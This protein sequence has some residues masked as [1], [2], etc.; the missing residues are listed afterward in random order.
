MTRLRAAVGGLVAAAVAAAAAT[1][2]AAARAATDLGTP[3]PYRV[4]HLTYRLPSLRVPDFAV[5]LEVVGEVEAPVGAPG[6]RPLVLVLHGMHRTCLK[7]SDVSA[8][9]PGRGWPCPPGWV[10]V[11]NHIGYRWLLR[12]LASQGDVAVSVSANSVNAQNNDVPAS[13]AVERALLVRHHLRLWA[14]WATTGG[15]PWGG[16]MRGA[17]DPQRVVLV[18]HSRGGEGVAQASASS[19]P[20]DA[21]RVRGLVLIAPTHFGRQVTPGVDE[22][23]VLPYCD[24]DVNDLEGQGYID[25]RRDLVAGD[26]TVRS[27]LLV[28]GANHNYFNTTWATDGPGSDDWF[29]DD[30]TPPAERRACGSRSR[31]RLTPS[32]QRNA[33]RPYVAAL[34]RAAVDDDPEAIAL[35][36]GTGARPASAGRAVTLVS[37]WG[38]GASVL[39]AP[40][41][42]AKA[43]RAARVSTRICRGYTQQGSDCLPAAGVERLPHW[44]PMGAAGPLPAPRALAMKWTRAGGAV[45][46]PLG[47][48]EAD[49]SAF[50]AVQMRVALGP[51][52]RGRPFALRLGDASGRT[53]VIEASSPALRALPGPGGDR[54]RL[55]P[56][57]W[58][59]SVRF[60]LD[61]TRLD[62]AHVTRAAILVRP[63][64]GRAWLLDVATVGPAAR[65]VTVPELPR[66]RARTVHVRERGDRGTV[67]VAVPV[68][69]EGAV[70]TSA[71]I[72]VLV[73]APDAGARW[74]VMEV[75][76]GA[77]R[78]MVPVTVTAD[79]LRTGPRRYGVAVVALRGAV[80]A[81]YDGAV[82]VDDDEPP[83]RVRV[84]QRRVSV[85]EGGDLVW[86]FRLSRVSSSDVSL[87]L[88]PALLAPGV[89]ALDTLDLPA[90]QRGLWGGEGRKPIPLSQTFAS[91]DVY[92]PAG[93]RT[94]QVSMPTLA[95]GRREPAEYVTWE[96]NTPGG[97]PGLIPRGFLLTGIVR[98]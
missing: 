64:S 22:L 16:A 55:L 32:A 48:A 92:F 57:V 61:P 58:A 6:A 33:V 20:D 81:R 4:Q 12:L 88:T 54:G 77:A 59:Q 23:V 73:S 62:L 72:A 42:G 84:E 40:R 49:L 21:F 13:G 27:A 90:E 17:V 83:V 96:G 65:P 52:L 94:A 39:Y 98:D 28:L 25:G 86:R 80:V 34:V 82:V 45:P 60:T 53:A 95:D 71:S 66:L 14:R 2:P 63:R 91:L 93:S 41:A 70:T 78:L 85:R 24:G 19:R 68:S 74:R 31:A 51:G 11:G 3:G 46:V 29:A 43:P 47:A 56:K 89:R 30:S 87:T 35:L 44:V 76:P 69:V 36:D 37:A 26:P 97:D 1:L 18:G 79:D 9:A 15:D 67:R 10:P 38:G 75:K 7:R 50:G 5:P 8:F